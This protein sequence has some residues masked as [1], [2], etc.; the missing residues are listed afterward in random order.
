MNIK[1]IDGTSSALHLQ[2]YIN[3]WLITIVIVIIG[4][5]SWS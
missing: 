4:T 2:H 1:V 3:I 5:I